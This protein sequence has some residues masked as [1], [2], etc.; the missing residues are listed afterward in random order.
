MVHDLQLSVGSP[1]YLGDTWALTTGL[2]RCGE[3]LAI[4][5]NSAAKIDLLICLNMAEEPAR[6]ELRVRRTAVAAI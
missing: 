3:D 6:Q 5:G 1:V 4:V 2:Q